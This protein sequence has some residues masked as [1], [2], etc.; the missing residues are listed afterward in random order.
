MGSGRHALIVILLLY[1]VKYYFTENNNEKNY[2]ATTFV[3]R[4]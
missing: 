2:R 1:N 3:C 4:I